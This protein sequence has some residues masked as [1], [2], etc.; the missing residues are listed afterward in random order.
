[1][2]NVIASVRV[3]PGKIADFLG[4]FKSVM[5]EVRKEKGCIEYFPALD[6][7]AKLPPQVLDE[8]IV[9][10][11]EK[12]ENLKALRDHLG[13]PHMVTYRKKVKYIVESVSLKILQET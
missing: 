5:H 1:M 3:K 11:I 10:I 9:T 7:D 12:W 6:V 2:I 4:I 13:A 8:Y